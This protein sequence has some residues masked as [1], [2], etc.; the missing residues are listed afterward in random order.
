MRFVALLRGINVGGNRKVPMAP[1]RSLVEGL[2][3][4]EVETLLQ[5][6]NVVFTADEEATGAPADALA[7][8]IE[9][10]FGFA[11]AVL[12]R[13]KADLVR[14]IAANPFPDARA[15]PKYLH[16][17]FSSRPVTVEALA[18]IDAER[19]APDEYRVGQDELYLWFPNG[20]GR[21]KLTIQL[22]E[23]ALAADLTARNWN[24]VTKL[25]DLLASQ[26]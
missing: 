20:S 5:S 19:F 21:S 26:G 15:E 8:A 25:R 11:V 7:A 17:A 23:K 14:V 13:T 16:V 22:F 2:G 1:L 10:E 4:T 24:T 12:V 3:H 9:A 6:G 18:G